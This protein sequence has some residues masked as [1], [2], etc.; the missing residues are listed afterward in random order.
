MTQY[1]APWGLSRI[2]HQ[3]GYGDTYLYDNSAGQ[4]TCAYVIDTGVDASHPVSG[5][6]T[7]LLVA[8]WT[9]P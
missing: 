3:N 7:W 5:I 6:P 4:G 1:N 9:P 8:C 2:S